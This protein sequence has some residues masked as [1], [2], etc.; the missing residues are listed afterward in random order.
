MEMYLRRAGMKFEPA[1]EAT[2]QAMAGLKTA[3]VYRCEVKRPR[4]YRFHKK[5]FALLNFAFENWD[6]RP[7]INRYGQIEKNFKQFRKDITIKSGY[8]EQH[9]RIDGSFR[10]VAKSISFASMEEDEFNKLYNAA[11]N[12]ILRMVLKSYSREDLDRVLVE[13]ER[14]AA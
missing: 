11:C 2:V 12:V 14:F 5:F 3:E 10:V 9:F 6:C 7:E 4:N 13:Y 1:D 8:Y